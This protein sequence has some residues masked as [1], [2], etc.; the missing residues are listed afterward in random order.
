MFQSVTQQGKKAGSVFPLEHLTT[1]ALGFYRIE[2]ANKRDCA[3]LKS[4]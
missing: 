3:N 1:T 2:V 4:F